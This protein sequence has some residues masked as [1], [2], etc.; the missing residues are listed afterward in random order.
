MNRRI[1]TSKYREPNSVTR[2]LMTAF[3][4]QVCVTERA[5]EP[6]LS[7]P[8]ANGTVNEIGF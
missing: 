5:A 7:C 1:V 2:A 4:A 6:T 8:A 3:S